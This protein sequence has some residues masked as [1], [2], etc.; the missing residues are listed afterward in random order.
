MAGRPSK[1]TWERAEKI[2]KRIAAGEPLTKICRDNDVPK[3]T[4]VYDWLW[5]KG[6][7]AEH[8]DEFAKRYDRAREKQLEAWSDQIIE[9]SD[10]GTN[11]CFKDLKYKNGQPR[12]DH[13]H[14]TRSRLRVDSRKWLLS[15]LNAKKFG[16]KV[17]FTSGGKAV[18]AINYV[19]PEDKSKAKE[20]KRQRK[21]DAAG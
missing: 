3:L 8:A 9:I 15:K 5:G 17:D 11:D 16:E 6:I 19:V 4:T 1:F 18:S 2:F 20:K 14:I 10:D 7:P 13:D 12:M 21:K